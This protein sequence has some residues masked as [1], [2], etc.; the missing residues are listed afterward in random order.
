MEEEQPPQSPQQTPDKHKTPTPAAKQKTHTHARAHRVV[1]LE[2]LVAR[3]AEDGRGRLLEARAELLPQ[4]LVLRV[5]HQQP[6]V[7]L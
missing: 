1:L 2:L 4:R 3:E 7:V 6:V 5:R